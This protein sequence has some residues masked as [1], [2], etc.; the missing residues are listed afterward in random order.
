MQFPL[1]P[2]ASALQA[3]AVL[4]RKGQLVAVEPWLCEFLR[5]KPHALEPLTLMALMRF[6]SGDYVN[7]GLLLQRLLELHPQ[8]LYTRWLLIQAMLQKGQLDVLEAEGEAIWAGEDQSQLLW[9]SRIAFLLN[10]SCF[11]EAQK[12]LDR[13]P[14]PCCLEAL[15]LQAR[16]LSLQGDFRGALNLLYPALQRAPRHRPLLA[17]L[18]ELVIDAREAKLVVPLARQ[19]LSLYGEHPDLLCHVTTVKLFQRQP[20]MARRSALMQQVWASV[21]PTP[22]NLANQICTYEQTGHTDWLIHLLQQYTNNPLADLP[23]HSNLAMH[24]ASIEAPSYSRHIVRMMKAVKSTQVYV[25]H[26]HAGLGV[27]RPA[28]ANR[29][30]RIAWVTGDLT[31]HPV[32]R[33][34]LGFFEASDR[35]REHSHCLVSVRDHGTETCADWFEQFYNLDF[36]DVSNLQGCHRVAAIRDL[37]ADVAIDLSGWTAGHFMAGFIARL[38]SVQVNYLGYFASAGITQ[39][40]YWIG[41]EQLFSANHCEWHTE[42]LWRLTCPFL[43]WQPASCLPEASAEVTDADAGPVHFGSF[44]HNRKLSDRTLRLWAAVL[45]CAPGSRLVLKA[46][47]KDDLSTQELL[48]R[49]MHRA[50]LDPE[51]VVWL[52]L[53]PTPA[54]HLHQYHHIDIALDPVPNGGCTTTCEALWMGVPVITLEGTTYVSRMSTAVLRGAG[55]GSWVCSSEEAYVQLAREKASEINLLRSSRHQWRRQV[56]KSPLGDAAGLMKHLEQAFS[57]MHVAAIKSL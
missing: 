31:P 3:L 48:R 23:L 32:S 44:N 38:A 57:A 56:A 24:L 17:Q 53:V 51:R 15:R 4:I 27:P 41:D 19:A 5:Q 25:Q 7:F 20:G 28:I 50:G 46:N 54:E 6:H 45:A 2:S 40:D 13:F 1:Q 39:M 55:L 22:I 12:L 42:K 14:S 9:L 35:R 18:L 47:A 10:R 8:A 29:P 34:L 30:L 43:A 21:R 16:S 49:R 37:Q 52:P 33:F 36:V 26:K 11:V